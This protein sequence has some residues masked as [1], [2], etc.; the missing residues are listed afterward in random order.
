MGEKVDFNAQSERKAAAVSVYTIEEC[1]QNHKQFGTSYEIVVVA[2][3][4]S[5]KDTVTFEQAQK[6][7]SAFMKRKPGK[8]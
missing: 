5:G 8:K 4:Q 1:A 7:V 2:L 3:K 6:I